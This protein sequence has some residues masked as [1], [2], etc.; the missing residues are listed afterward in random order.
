MTARHRNSMGRFLDKAEV[1][2]ALS[3]VL[4]KAHQQKIPCA[5]V[6]GLAM[7]LYGSPRLTADV[8]VAAQRPVAG[9]KPERRLSFGGFATHVGRVPVDVIV[10][11]DH[12]A[13]LYEEAVLSARSNVV[14]PEHLATMKLAAMRER[15]EQDLKFLLVNQRVNL[16]KLRGI[17]SRYLGPYGLDSLESYVL[18]AKWL[19]AQARKRR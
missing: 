18:E 6:G 15:D 8:D 19:R 17:V 13:R 9:L 1:D 16:A 10:R 14:S 4:T 12:Y 11:S 3:V 5:I 2:Q 7:A